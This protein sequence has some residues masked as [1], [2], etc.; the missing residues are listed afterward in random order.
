[1]C[2][3]NYTYTFL[4]RGRCIDSTYT[5]QHHAYTT[6]EYRQADLLIDTL[7]KPS[8]SAAV[9]VHVVKCTEAVMKS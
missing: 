5:L 6:H 4:A 9:H 7:Q 2:M 1:M 3:Y 8:V